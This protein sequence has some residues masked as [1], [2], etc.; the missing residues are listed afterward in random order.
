MVIETV[1]GS[2]MKLY[3]KLGAKIYTLFTIPII[4]FMIFLL[5][6]FFFK[7]FLVDATTQINRFDSLFYGKYTE[8]K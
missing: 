6:L 3:C 5:R 1:I 2:K 7:N 4:D 8:V